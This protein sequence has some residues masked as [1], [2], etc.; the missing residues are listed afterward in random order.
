[1]FYLLTSDAGLGVSFQQLA[2]PFKRSLYATRTH[3]RFVAR[4]RRRPARA[5][6]KMQRHD[7]QAQQKL[8]FKEIPHADAPT[9]RPYRLQVLGHLT[10][11]RF[12]RNQ[13]DLRTAVN[14]PG[15]DLKTTLTDERHAA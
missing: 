14:R 15:H 3:A 6:I 12:R 1:M 4:N 2:Q 7:R 13:G 10:S 5:R 8:L 11:L 9:R